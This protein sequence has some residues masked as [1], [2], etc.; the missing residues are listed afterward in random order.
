MFFGCS[1]NTA[2]LGVAPGHFKY[3]SA[4]TE[5]WRPF[6]R[7]YGGSAPPPSWA[8]GGPAPPS[9]VSLFIPYKEFQPLL[10]HCNCIL[11]TEPRS[12]LKTKLFFQNSIFV[13]FMHYLF[14][15]ADSSLKRLTGISVPIPRY[16]KNHL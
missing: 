12:N 1:R 7:A 11:E 3:S 15:K 2:Q 9:L 5:A 6:C 10:H 4:N 8:H 13:D 14:D 16:P